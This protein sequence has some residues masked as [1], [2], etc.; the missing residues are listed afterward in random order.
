LRSTFNR[1]LMTNVRDEF[2]S[3]L[4]EF[5]N[6]SITVCPSLYI[7][8]RMRKSM[9]KNYTLYSHHDELVNEIEFEAIKTKIAEF[10]KAYKFTNNIQSVQTCFFQILNLYNNSRLIVT[11]R[12]HGAIIAYGFKIPYIALARDIKIREFHRLYGN[13]LLIEGIN[14][15]PEML[16]NRKI[17]SLKEIKI[18][19]VTDFGEK[20]K[21]ITRSLT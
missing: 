17:I 21:S 13:G 19:P 18:K 7:L 12:L 10:D 8:D 16:N 20:V 3:S 15:L 1:L 9:Y 6:P 5:K 2:T 4:Y 11:S 14:E